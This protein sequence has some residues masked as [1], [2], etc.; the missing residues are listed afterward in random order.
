VEILNGGG[1]KGQR[2]AGTAK[3]WLYGGHVEQM[4]TAP[5]IDQEDGGS[6]PRRHAA[7]N[8]G[9]QNY[10]R[11]TR[12]RMQR[13]TTAH[14]L[15]IA[16]QLGR[17]RGGRGWS[18]VWTQTG[19]QHEARDVC[20]GVGREPATFRRNPRAE[21]ATRNSRHGFAVLGALGVLGVAGGEEGRRR[22]GNR[23]CG[24]QGRL[25]RG[26]RLFRGLS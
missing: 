13:R 12:Q 26:S 24:A 19:D 15:T 14:R 9:K 18:G 6:R 11:A 20:S 25:T 17:P 22:L 2:Y 21:Q 3:G 5:A 8:T 10:L 16:G 23:S 7:I 4:A 1:G